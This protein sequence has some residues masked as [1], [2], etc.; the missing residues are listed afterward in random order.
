[1]ADFFEDFGKKISDAAV[2]IGRRTEDTIEVQKL[3]SEIRT[4]NRGN[5][6]DYMDIGKA[7]YDSYQ[8]GEVIDGD[9]AALCE[10]IEKRGEKV[11]ELTEEIKKIRGE[12]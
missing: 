2:E 8:K 7:V 12:V 10:A 5:E 11:Q 6:R 1:M 3:K 4:L 9:M